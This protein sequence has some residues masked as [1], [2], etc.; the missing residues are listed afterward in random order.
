MRIWAILGIAT[1]IIGLGWKIYDLGQTNAAQ[2]FELATRAA[3]IAKLE[4]DAK[5][6]KALEKRTATLKKRLRHAEN[7]YKNI[8][9]ITGCFRSSVP[10]SAALELFDLYG[11][12]TAEKGYEALREGEATLSG[13]TAES[14][15]VA[16][17]R[18]WQ[19][20]DRLNGQ[21]EK[22]SR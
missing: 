16:L 11:S 19:E 17:G 5:D 8:K 6:V 14:C 20:T 3:T 15:L 7:L 21:L 2:K 1:L 22:L 18:Q 4:A 12:L 9:D 13:I 10:R